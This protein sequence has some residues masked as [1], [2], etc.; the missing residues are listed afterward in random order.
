MGTLVLLDEAKNHWQTGKDECGYPTY[1][2]GVRYHQVST[3]EVYGALGK[4]GLFTETTPIAPN[5][6]YSASRPVLTWW[7]DLMDKPLNCQ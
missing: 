4:T 3:D 7:S 6:P 2:D 1:R 5:S